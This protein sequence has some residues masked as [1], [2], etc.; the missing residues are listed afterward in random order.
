MGTHPINL[1]VRFILELSALLA[2]GYWGWKQSDNWFRYILALAIPIA[3]AAIWGV[4][5]VPDDPSRSGSAPVPV[6]GMVRLVIELAFFA[7]ATWCLY[8]MGAIRWSWILGLTVAIH[9]IV[10]YDRIIWLAER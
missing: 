1:M 6:P 9:Y 7:F 8:D 3:L 10:S 5:A 4:F 2:S